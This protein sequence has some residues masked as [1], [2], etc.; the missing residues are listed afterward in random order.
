MKRK[1]NRQTLQGLGGFLFIEPSCFDGVYRGMDITLS[2]L[3]SLAKEMPRGHSQ[4][5]GEK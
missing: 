4:L 1:V 3:S 2:P 5:G